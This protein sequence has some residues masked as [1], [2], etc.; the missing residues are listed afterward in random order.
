WWVGGGGGGVGGEIR[1][2]GSRGG[3]G[4]GRGEPV[5]EMQIL[6]GGRRTATVVATA[7]TELARIER[8]AIERLASQDPGAMRHL[9]DGIRRRGGG[10]QLA[11]VL[12]GLLGGGDEGV[13]RGVAAAVPWVTLS[14]GTVLFEEGDPGDRAYILVSGRLQASVRDA[15][16]RDRVVGE[17]VRG[18]VV[19][20]MAVFTGEPRSACVRALRDSE[21]VSL[22]RPAFEQLIAGRRQTLRGLTRLVVQRLR[23]A[24]G[25]APAES[26]AQ[27]FAMIAAGPGVPL[28][29]FTRRLAAALGELGSTLHL[30]AADL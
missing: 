26:A 6:W 2:R 30:A 4:R 13:L 22:D 12:P 3:G 17:I 21:L 18:E 20:E 29:D 10:N 5:G 25:S 9:A 16:G 24:Q 27:T 28:A 23:R 15:A 7:E 1:G 19:G 14:R 8:A 11:A